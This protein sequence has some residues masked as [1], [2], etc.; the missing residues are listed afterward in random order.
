MKF[1]RIALSVAALFAS[2]TTFAGMVTGSSNI[3]ILA[4]DGQKVSKSVLTDKNSFDMSAGAKHQVVLRVSEIVREGADR[5]LFESDPIVVTFQSSDDDI[6]ISAPHLENSR[7]ADNFKKSPTLTVITRSGSVVAFQQDYLKREGFLPNSDLVG[8]LSE[9]NSS[10]LKAAVRE[11]ASTTMPA[12]IPA[13]VKGKKGK[14]VVQ[15][16]NVVEQQLQ[17]WFQ[18]ADAETQVRFLKWASK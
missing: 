10:G 3:D 11:F 9:Y 7:D 1:Q 15:G 13:L 5:T 16:E 18:Q 17:Y 8:T 6:M 2:A 12:A 14:V 4:L